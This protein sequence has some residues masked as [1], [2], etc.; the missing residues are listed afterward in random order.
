M[1][2]YSG[3]SVRAYEACVR[4]RIVY[5]TGHARVQMLASPLMAAE[6]GATHGL[7]PSA[8]NTASSFTC[9]VEGCKEHLGPLP[10][11][12]YLSSGAPSRRRV[13]LCAAH[14]AAVSLDLGDGAGL[15]RYCQKVGLL[16]PLRITCCLA[17]AQ[18]C[19][20]RWAASHCR[21]LLPLPTVQLASSSCT[22]SRWLSL[23]TGRGHKILTRTL[24]RSATSWK[25]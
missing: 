6:A 23:S 16:Q 2:C 11:A 3:R 20:S 10:T 21:T 25:A 18:P 17:L 9:L 12:K 19:G 13:R 22:V 5:R 7:L 8:P 15:V 4:L 24:A 14:K 1:A